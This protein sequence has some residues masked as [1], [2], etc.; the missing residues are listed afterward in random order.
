MDGVITDTMPY[1]YKAWNIVFSK[2]KVKMSRLDIYSREGQSSA[3]CV[4]EIFALN[5]KTISDQ[6][7]KQIL[8]QK[9][10]IFKKIFKL[11]FIAGS[12]A[13]IRRLYSQG[14]RIGLV[15]GTARHELLEILPKDLRNLFDAIVTGD[16][17]KNG[18]PHPEP[19]R[20]ALKMLQ[21]KKTDAVVIE[22]APLGI[23]SAKAAGLKCLAIETS[24]PKKYLKQADHIFHS[25]KHLK[26]RVCF[27]KK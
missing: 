5:G 6:E 9:E 4:K 1:H 21:C 14:F 22:N 26:S 24:L 18:K 16:E 13:F 10:R 12:R 27:T 23:Q 20:K 11:R 2:A 19:Y 7:V 3:P 17:V 25:F 15:T 8:A